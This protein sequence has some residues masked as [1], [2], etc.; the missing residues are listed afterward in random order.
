MLSLVVAAETVR[1]KNCRPAV[2][3]IAAIV[4]VC[5]SIVKNAVREAR[6]LGLLTV[7]ER[8]VTG[9]RN[10]P[11]VVRIV[12][13]GVDGLAAADAERGARNVPPLGTGGRGQIRNPHAY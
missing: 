4:G 6:K 2:E 13:A 10:L 9:F 11:N 1:R 12:S 7:A 3:H 8:P 5:R